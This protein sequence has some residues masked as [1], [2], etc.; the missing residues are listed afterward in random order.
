MVPPL[1][2][3]LDDLV[4]GARLVRGLPSFVRQP[5]GLDEARAVLQRRFEARA[6]D[7]LAVARLALYGRAESPYRRLL[8]CAGCEYGDLERLVA[9]DGVEGALETLLREGIYLSVEEFKGRR[10]V[11]RGSTEFQVDTRHFRNPRVAGHLGAHTGGSRGA[12]SLVAIDLPCIRDWAVNTRFELEA[13]GGRAWAPA[14]W[15]IPGGEAVAGILRFYAGSGV[16][17]ARWF[18]PLDPS[19][20][21][22][23]PRYRWSVRLLRWGSR[24]GGVAVPRP[25]HVPLEDPRPIVDW[26]AGVLRSGRTPFLVAYVSSVVRLARAALESGIDL[27][28]THCLGTGEPLT[29]ARR[30][31]VRRAGIE[32]AASYASMEVGPIGSGCLAPTAPDDI[33]LFHDLLALVQPAGQANQARPLF[34]STLRPSAPYLLINVSLGDQAVVGRRRC[35]CLLG[36][37]GWRTHLHGIRSFEKLTAGGMSFLDTDI[38]RV[39]EEVLPS[40]FGGAPTDYQL[41]EDED[42]TGRARLR[43]LVHPALG[44]VDPQA[45]AATFLGAISEG[46]GAER[47]MGLAWRDAGLLRVDRRPPLTTAFGKI[48]HLHVSPQRGRTG[49]GYEASTGT[50]RP[51]APAETAR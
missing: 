11:V 30:A 6:A 28:G 25:R 37:V 46:V 7:F 49:D 5:V 45:V 36:D 42:E 20:P 10:P 39:L 17:L 18:S 1:A 24:L 12:P 9:R 34:A 8:Q 31:A 13:H 4:A 16:P 47:V 40:R 33:H 15:T 44:P 26:L 50:P 21:E 38:I 32:I 43:L 48:Q 3:S 41:V 35:G 23:P 51:G 22:L 19:S 29:A 2:T 14:R 27:S